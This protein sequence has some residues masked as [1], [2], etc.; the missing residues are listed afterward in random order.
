[1][2]AWSKNALRRSTRA[3]DNSLIF[4]SRTPPIFFNVRFTENS[5]FTKVN[6]AGE[7]NAHSC[8]SSAYDWINLQLAQTSFNMRV[9]ISACLDFNLMDF[10]VSLS[11]AKSNASCMASTKVR[12]LSSRWHCSRS[13]YHPDEHSMSILFG[14]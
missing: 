13:V 2:I 11:C 5:M 7:D 12:T 9:R 3:S 4:L 10:K 8:E 14:K 6:E 1:M